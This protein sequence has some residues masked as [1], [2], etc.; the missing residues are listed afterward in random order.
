MSYE[1]IQAALT[2]LITFTAIAGFGGIVAHAMWKQHQTWMQ[3]YCPLVAPLESI[4]PIDNVNSKSKYLQVEIIAP[5]EPALNREPA[6]F[7]DIWETAIAS[8]SPRYWVRPTPQEQP[9][10]YLL[11]PAKEEVKLATKKSRKAAS[12]T[13]TPATS[14]RK[15]AA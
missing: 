13:K 7:E 3:T 9:T 15:K 8:S 10:L 6:E 4:L 12:I 5:I 14:K 11:P 2:N 1:F